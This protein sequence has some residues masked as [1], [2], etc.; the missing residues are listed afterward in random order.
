[1]PIAAWVVVLL[2]TNAAQPGEEGKPYLDD[3]VEAAQ[4][5]NDGQL[6][7]GIAIF[8]RLSIEYDFEKTKQSAQAQSEVCRAF[9][10]ALTPEAFPDPDP[11]F[12]TCP[13]HIISPWL[14]ENVFSA[15]TPAVEYAPRPAYPANAAERGL[16][17]FVDLMVDID[18]N[19]FPTNIR[20]THSTSSHFEKNAIQAA[21]GTRFRP[22]K[23][24]G[25][26]VV[27]KD[28]SY[29]VKF[30]LDDNDS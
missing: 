23:Y 9:T 7:Y 29:R 26:V 2:A 21:E 20:V 19:G 3:L 11:I 16:E 22:A 17:G 6:H 10:S 30:R 1:M 25:R 12:W 28:F 24:N 4:L 13:T 15:L 5:V 14:G 18:V 8:R 27:R